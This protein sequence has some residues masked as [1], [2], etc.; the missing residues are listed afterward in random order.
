MKSIR[1][2]LLAA[3]LGTALLPAITAGVGIQRTAKLSGYLDEMSGN[4]IPSL[5][6]LQKIDHGLANA[7]LETRAS[8]LDLEMKADS[9]IEQDRK[10][11]DEALRELDAGK[12]L[13]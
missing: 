13:Y 10:R 8:M 5:I 7:L 9:R 12:T 6:G 3:F 2:T 11:R 4:L 1:G